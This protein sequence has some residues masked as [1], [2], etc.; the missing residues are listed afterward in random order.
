MVDSGSRLPLCIVEIFQWFSW[1]LC[2]E[3]GRIKQQDIVPFAFSENPIDGIIVVV[4][5]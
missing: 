2:I 4:L 3:C 1:W 5:V